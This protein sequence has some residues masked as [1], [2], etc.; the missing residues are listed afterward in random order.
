MRMIKPG[1]LV[2]TVESIFWLNSLQLN[3]TKEQ[4]NIIFDYLPQMLK[5]K[6]KNFS[7]EKIINTLFFD[8]YK[9]EKDYNFL[10]RNIEEI[11]EDIVDI[12]HDFS[13]KEYS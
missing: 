13:I 12:I 1:K 10:R 9:N 8:Q 6:W 7:S 2:D 5:N 3:L 11:S 4:K